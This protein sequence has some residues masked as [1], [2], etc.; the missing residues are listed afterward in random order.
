MSTTGPV[1][2]GGVLEECLD[3]LNDSIAA[4]EEYPHTVLA[5]ALRIQLAALLRALNDQGVCTPQE[6]AEFLKDLEREVLEGD[7][8]EIAGS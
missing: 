7:S 8:E 1:S 4:L 5:F 6:T 3:R 2:V